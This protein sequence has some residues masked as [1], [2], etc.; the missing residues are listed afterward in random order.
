MTDQNKLL[1]TLERILYDAKF[2]A[3]TRFGLGDEQ[4]FVDPELAESTIIAIL[5]DPDREFIGIDIDFFVNNIL[6][7]NTPEDIINTM[8]SIYDTFRSDDVNFIF[9]Q[10]L[11]DAFVNKKEFEEIFK[12]SWVA[13]QIKQNVSAPEQAPVDNL[14]IEPGG[15]CFVDPALTPTVTPSVT[16]TLAE[17]QNSPTPT[18][19]V[20][21][22]ISVTPTV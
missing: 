13:L 6:N 10:I 18:P 2:G 16:P 1:P 9:F 3:D 8:N 4:I 14:N 12:T 22:T 17:I 15:G 11:Q 19:T 20:T 5:T 21:P 7:F